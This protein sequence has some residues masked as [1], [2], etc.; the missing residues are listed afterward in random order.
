[1]RK[2]KFHIILFCILIFSNQYYGQNTFYTNSIF[3][4]NDVLNSINIYNI[5][6]NAAFLVEKKISKGLKIKTDLKNTNGELRK[7]TTP[8]ETN[9]YTISFMGEKEITPNQVFKG[10]FSFVK[11]VRKNRDWITSKN[12]ETDTPF[13]IADSSTGTMRYNYLLL[14]AQYANRI[15]KHILLGADIIYGVDEGLKKVFPRPVTSNRDIRISLGAAYSSNSFKL[16]VSSFYTD[17]IDEINYSEDKGALYKQNVLIQFRGYD[18]PIIS[19]KRSF[20]WNSKRKT[21]GGNISSQYNWKS[22]SFFVNAKF[23]KGKNNFY[24]GAEK[25]IDKGFSSDKVSLF[26]FFISN[27]VNRNL[28]LLLYGKYYSKSIWSR[29]PEYDILVFEKDI[30]YKLVGLGGE[31]KLSP[32]FS[33]LANVNYRFSSNELNDYYSKLNYKTDENILCNTVSFNYNINNTNVILVE[34]THSFPLKKENIYSK[35]E[36]SKY[37]SDFLSRNIYYELSE[38]NINKLLIRWSSNSFDMFAF[39]LYLNY[40]HQYSSE[41]SMMPSKKFNI[42]NVGIELQIK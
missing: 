11:D 16:G 27:K 1:M 4:F 12:T 26:D 6:N 20:K 37:Y 36:S 28:K 10:K 29:H 24:E 40:M 7:F 39:S 33:L 30:N 3:S 15:T 2:N 38:I 8:G 19:H 34:Y 42:I 25:R 32:K 22:Y 9:I 23:L 5:S 21:L 14:N 31:L 13:L 18:Y 17:L 35:K 41:D